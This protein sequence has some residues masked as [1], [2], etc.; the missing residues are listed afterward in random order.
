MLAMILAVG[1]GASL[2][3]QTAINAQLRT[4]VISPF[5]ASMI[6]FAI[7]A[8]FLSA[9][10]LLTGSSLSVPLEIFTREPG[11]IWLGGL[12]GV[13]GLTTNILLFPKL[14]S[15][16]TAVIPI[17]GMT[18][19]SMLIDHYGWFHS[20]S[21][22]FGSTRTMGI[23]LVLLGV[24]LA[25]AAQ[26]VLRTRRFSKATNSTNQVSQWIWRMVGIGAGML[27]SVQIAV[28]GQLG[29]VLDSPFHAAFV[30]F[31]VGS[32]T[33]ILVVALR[34]R[35]YTNVK[36]PIRQFAPWWV[37]IGGILGGTYVL[38]NVFLVNQLGTGQTVILA[39]LGQIIGS[40]F[41]EQFGLLRSVKNRIQPIQIV[42]ILVML[43][44]VVLIR[45]F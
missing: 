43:A 36:E 42:G 18:L 21:Q 32:I 26:D 14:G 38:I 6:S 2:A 31:F 40:L 19:M 28:N 17:L 30:S 41:V 23:T 44:G 29:R 15:V 9:A 25:I 1:I 27:M 39:L 34:D 33:L 8:I 4:Y 5:L 22:P 35:S 12:C 7:A 11:W 10:T 37:W 13:I 24:F 45:M 3:V 16:Q 20:I